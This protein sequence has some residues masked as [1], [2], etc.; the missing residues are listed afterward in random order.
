MIDTVL[1]QPLNG[2][3]VRATVYRQ[4]VDLLAQGRAD[5]DA[6]LAG[7]AYAAID[8]LRDDVPRD[9]RAGMANALAGQPISER[10]VVHFAQEQVRDVARFLSLAVLEERHWLAILPG[11]PS[12]ARS[13]LRS[14][15]DLPEGVNVALE[16]FGPSDLALAAP[17]EPELPWTEPYG[18]TI[19]PQQRDRRDVGG[20]VEVEVEAQTQAPIPTQT[21]EAPSPVRAAPY[22]PPPAQ[23]GKRRADHLFSSAPE[24]ASPVEQPEKIGRDPSLVDGE[25][26]VRELLRRIEEF[27]ARIP[28]K[29]A[30]HVNEAGDGAGENAPEDNHVVAVEPQPAASPPIPALAPIPKLRPAT[31]T[32]PIPAGPGFRWETDVAGTIV[33]VEG[34]PREAVIGRSVALSEPEPIEGVDLLA[35]TAFARRAPFR[36]GRLRLPGSGEASGLWLISGV[37][38]FDPRGGKFGGFRGTA[39]RFEEPVAA[40]PIVVEVDRRAQPKQPPSPDAVRQMAHELRTPLNAIVGF[41]EM[42]DRQMLGPAAQ[43]YRDRAQD[44][45]SDAHRLLAAID[46]MD[47]T[48]R[49]AAGASEGPPL[50]DAGRLVEKVIGRYRGLSRERGIDL[51]GSIAIGLPAI[52]TSEEVLERVVSRLFAAVIGAARAGDRL[53]YGVGLGERDSVRIFLSRPAALA[54][55]DAETLYD[56][57]LAGFAVGLE[58]PALGLGFGLRLVRQLASALGGQFEI[59]DALFMLTLPCNRAKT[60]AA[61]TAA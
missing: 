11:L 37:P 54:G 58:A 29:P 45:V 57:A 38:F 36:D 27:R 52:E 21:P 5:H 33:W 12:Q 50:V 31:A 55:R 9:L 48:A 15:R 35:A 46:D 6:G 10:L 23:A 39:R 32:T 42:I 14:R 1:S 17:E 40:E 44:I 56:P 20:E 16:A 59:E 18:G 3:S 2:G 47:A 19:A 30:S 51:I 61:G 25:M 34:V 7:R 60:S 49:D 13:L 8:A 28:R 22:I 43:T 41:A 4:L 26:Q 24:P 53:T